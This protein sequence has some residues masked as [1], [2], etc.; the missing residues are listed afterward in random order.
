MSGLAECGGLNCSGARYLSTSAPAWSSDLAAARMA[1]A[2]RLMARGSGLTMPRLDGVPREHHLW[3]GEQAAAR[4]AAA[5][6]RAGLASEGDWYRARRNPFDFVKMTL[7][8]WVAAHWAAEIQKEFRL[9]L[10]LSTSLDRYFTDQEPSATSELY[11]TIEPESAGYVVLGP[12]LRT[13][14]TIHPQLPATFTHTFLGSLNR[15]V[16]VYDWRDALERVDMLR[17]WYESDPP[18]TTDEVRL[19]DIESSIPHC[20]KQRPLSRKTLARI[21]PTTKDS[22]ARHL[23][24]NLLDIER[25][26]T[27]VIRPVVDEDAGA[28]LADCGEVLPCLLAVFEKHD[29]IEGQFDAESQGMLEVTPE[30]NLI[31]RLNGE[32]VGSVRDGFDRLAACCETLACA[33][34]LMKIMP[35]NERPDED[36]V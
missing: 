25:A 3:Q 8:R 33:T 19:P 2:D 1:A 16:R 30:P 17:E 20:M 34:R 35:G 22:T 9:D 14:E 12:T 24:E 7:N 29:T 23:V 26:A 13:L 11:L 5:F 15:W 4:T 32:D 31:I 10:M 27:R 6:L 36:A 18:E 28:M 21:G